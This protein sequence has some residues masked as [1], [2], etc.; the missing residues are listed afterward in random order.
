MSRG[1]ICMCAYLPSHPSYYAPMKSVPYCPTSGSP[2][3]SYVHTA[4]AITDIQ[5]LSAAPHVAPGKLAISCYVL[6][7][8][9]GLAVARL[10]RMD[11]VWCCSWFYSAGPGMAFSPW[12][13]FQSLHEFHRV[14]C[15]MCVTEWFFPQCVCFA[16]VQ[17][18]AL[19][20]ATSSCQ[21]L[22]R[23]VQCCAML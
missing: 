5:F 22:H 17:R 4:V 6:C 7:L 1:R 12:Y 2:A 23:T 9:G 16:P 8:C 14:F 18:V 11:L 21:L 15:I 19:H 13:G 10:H 3:L 20:G